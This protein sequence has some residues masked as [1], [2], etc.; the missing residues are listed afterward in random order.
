MIFIN[1]R[2]FEGENRFIN[3]N[4]SDIIESQYFVKL[5]QNEINNSVYLSQEIVYYAFLKK[6]KKKI[7]SEKISIY[8]R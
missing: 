5:I 6:K 3:P 8:N 4:F 1:K 7:Q 2:N